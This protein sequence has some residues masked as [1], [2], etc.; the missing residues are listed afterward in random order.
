M[1]RAENKTHEKQ[2][3]THEQ[4]IRKKS[5]KRHDERAPNIVHQMKIISQN[6]ASETEFSDYRRN[7]F[8]LHSTQEKNSYLLKRT[9]NECNFIFYLVFTLS[10]VV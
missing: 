9:S 3:S 1:I 10:F 4:Q 5:N 8:R 7:V 6:S 2:N